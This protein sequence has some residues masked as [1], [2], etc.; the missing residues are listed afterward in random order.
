MADDDFDLAGDDEEEE[1]EQEEQKKGFLGGQQWTKMLMY[2][3]GILVVIIISVITSVFINQW[4]GA[5]Q[6]TMPF[7][8]TVPSTATPPRAVYT[9]PEFKLALDKKEEE[10]MTTIVQVKLAL[11][12]EKDNQQIINEIIARK[13]QIRDR[14]QYVIAKKKYE[15]IN[16]ARSREEQLKQDLLYMVNSIMTEGEILDVY[17]DQFVV[18]RIPG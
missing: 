7:K 12:Y 13:E 10:S 15:D 11:A 5:T 8:T 14:V 18:S 1:G 2:T 6:Q 17:F 4:I 9:L 16:V 3:A